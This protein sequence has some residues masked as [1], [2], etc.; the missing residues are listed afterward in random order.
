LGF[1]FNSACHLN[2]QSQD[3]KGKFEERSNDFAGRL[4]DF[5]GCSNDFVGCPNDFA[6]CSNKEKG[7]AVFF[8]HTGGVP[9]LQRLQV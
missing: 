7:S 2:Y 8:S 1:Q 9:P 6:G 5:A 3:K 4:N